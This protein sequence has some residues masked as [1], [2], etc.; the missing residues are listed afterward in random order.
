MNALRTPYYRLTTSLWNS[1]LGLPGHDRGDTVSII[2][3]HGVHT[4]AMTARALPPSSSVSADAFEVNVLGLLRHYRV[5]SLGDAVAM[6]R[7]EAPWRSKCAVLTFDDSLKCTVDVAFSILHRLG[8]TA[9]IFLSTAA[10]EGRPYWWLRLDYLWATATGIR[11]RVQVPREEA[12]RALRLGDAGDLV[13]LKKVLKNC[14]ARERDTVVEALECQAGT[15]LSNPERQY[16][17]A[18]PLSWQDARALVARGFDV[19][20]HSVNHSNL[21]L[22]PEHEVHEELTRSKSEIER[23]LPSRCRFFSYPYGAHTDRTAALAEKCGYE[24]AVSTVAPGRNKRGDGLF[25]LRRYSIP[26]APHKLPYLLSGAA[27]FV[28]ATRDRLR[29]APVRGAVPAHP[30]GGRHG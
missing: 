24:A 8:L 12:P 29:N 11:A 23:Q 3:F 27:G 13:R 2:D 14:N 26:G 25:T 19:G 9:T 16:P 6:L 22:L 15:A 18:T 17:H 7:G 4:A 21:T 30:F 10:V 28:G 20:S 5:I 1:G